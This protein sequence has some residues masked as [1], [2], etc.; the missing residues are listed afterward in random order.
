M[1]ARVNEL[2]VTQ[3]PPVVRLIVKDDLERTRVTVFFRLFLAIPHLIWLFIWSIGTFFV[4]IANWF[5]ALFTGRPADSLHR[6]LSRYIR[7]AVHVRA[8]LGLAANRFPDFMGE[9]YDIDVELPPPMPQP[10]WKTLLR[11]FLALP[12]LI[13][14][15]ALG[16]PGFAGGTAGR[17]GNS[18]QYSGGGVS[19]GGLLAVAA[20]LG[21]FASLARGRMPRGLRD[22]SAYSLGFGAQAAAYLFL[23]T[24]RY[25]DAD[26]VRMLE[27]APPNVDEPHPV[28]LETE[29]EL[30]RSRVTVFFRIFLAIPHL[31]WVTLWAIAIFFTSIVNWFVAVFTGRPA[32]SLQRF[33][34]AFVRYLAHLTAYIYLVANP[35]PGFTGTPGTYPIEIEL[36]P[37]TRQSRWTIGFRAFLAIPAAFVSGALGNAIF[38]GAFYMWFTGVFLGRVPRSLRNLGVYSIR[39]STQLNAYALLVTERYPHASPLVPTGATEEPELTG[40]VGEPPRDTPEDPQPSAG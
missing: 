7:Y 34:S 13:M 17:G 2:E 1:I 6:F 18:G 19:G 16:G 24:E 4:A 14:S 32:D 27:S 39:Y 5:V 21:W 33:S 38:I 30:R 10:R 28:L 22:A 3:E 31:I 12:A 20:F 23:V 29:E 15:V 9:R 11:L 40:W 25:P 26:P 36:P 37:R 8:Y 35:F